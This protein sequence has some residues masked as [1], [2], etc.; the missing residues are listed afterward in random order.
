MPCDINRPVELVTIYERV[1]KELIS[2]HLVKGFVSGG[3]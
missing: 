1:A 3:G 2:K